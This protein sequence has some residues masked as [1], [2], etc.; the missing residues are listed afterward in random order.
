MSQFEGRRESR[1][2][3]GY[4]LGAPLNLF[5][6]NQNSFFVELKRFGGALKGF[7]FLPLGK[8]DQRHDGWIPRDNDRERTWELLLEANNNWEINIIVTSWNKEGYYY[9]RFLILTCSYRILFQ[10]MNKAICW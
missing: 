4:I 3:N 2:E 9:L 6:F 1:G 10:F 5:L 7:R 8:R